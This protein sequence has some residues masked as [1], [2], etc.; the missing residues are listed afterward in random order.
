MINFYEPCKINKNDSIHEIIKKINHVKGNDKY[1]PVGIYI[2]KDKIIGI[3][4]L[5]DIRRI[6]LKK[7]NFNEPAIKHLNKKT[8]VINNNLFNADLNNKINFLK[9]SKKFIDFIISKDI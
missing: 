4:S 1:Y 9:K 2:E 5:G 3:L 8:E 6:A 7:I